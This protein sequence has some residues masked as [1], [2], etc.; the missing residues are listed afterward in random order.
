ESTEIKRLWPPFNSAQ[1]KPEDVFGIFAYED[2]AG[3]MRLAIEKKRR[4]ASPVYTFHYKI[5]GHDLIRRLMKEFDL[6]PKLCFMQT[7]PDACQGIADAHCHGACE[8][9][10][11]HSIYNE[12]VGKA[13]ASLL[14]RPSYLLL[15]KGLQDEE[16]S[17]IMVVNGSFFGMG[18]LPRDV[19][20]TSSASIQEYI[21][22]YKE[23]SYIK[24]LLNSYI[25]K[26]PGR[27][28]LLHDLD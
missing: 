10:E 11:A 9:K 27:I 25:S 6:C 4:H 16:Q 18:Y 12:R 8:K 21:Q 17:C 24:T 7:G 22:P 23:N 15:D 2:Q 20:I 5:G 28:R 26:N 3:Y 1:K 19:A 13:I 14:S